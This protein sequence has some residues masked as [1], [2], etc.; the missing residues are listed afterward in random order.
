MAARRFARATFL[1]VFAAAATMIGFAGLESRLRRH[2]RESGL[3]RRQGGHTTP[4]MLPD[5]LS[6]ITITGPQALLVSNNRYGMNDVAG[7]D[8]RARLDA[9]TL[10]VAAV[11]A[12]EVVVDADTPRIP[13]GVD[14]ETVMMPTPIRCAIR[15]KVLRV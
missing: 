10:G 14:G 9:G 12:G 1:L 7:L 6:G 4:R 2:C 5:I 3:S 13:V 8:R 11:T 15:P